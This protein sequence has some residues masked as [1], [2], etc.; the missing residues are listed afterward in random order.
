MI[1]IIITKMPCLFQPPRFPWP[2]ARIISLVSACVWPGSVRTCRRDALLLLLE[3]AGVADQASEAAQA[4]VKQ[5]E[6]AI[7]GV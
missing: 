2:R 7:Q 6:S 3:R 5:L 1:L 4:Y